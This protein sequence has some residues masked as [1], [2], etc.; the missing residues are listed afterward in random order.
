MGRP[1]LEKPRDVRVLVRVL[2]EERA[3]WRDAASRSGLKL[4]AW[5]RKVANAAAKRKKAAK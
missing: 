4:S 2:L 5:I 1:K 3:A